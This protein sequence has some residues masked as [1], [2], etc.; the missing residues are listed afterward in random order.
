ML[1]LIFCFYFCFSDA[2]A[3]NTF[4]SDLETGKL[5]R[6]FHHGP[7]VVVAKK[8]IE[9]SHSIFYFT[10]AVL[11]FVPP[12]AAVLICKNLELTGLTKTSNLSVLSNFSMQISIFR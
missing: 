6:E 7:D 12:C 3:L 11:T 2:D 1:L 9:V 4:I 5:H 8:A 10:A